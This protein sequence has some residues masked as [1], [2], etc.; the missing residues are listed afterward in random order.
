M[1]VPWLQ[2]GTAGPVRLRALRPARGHPS[3]PRPLRRLVVECVR[4]PGLGLELALG[5]VCKGGPAKK[6]FSY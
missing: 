2:V 3:R 6:L 4:A 5:S 1:P